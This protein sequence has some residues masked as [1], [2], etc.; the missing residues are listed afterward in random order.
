LVPDPATVGNAPVA[1]PPLR[2]DK[3]C[4]CNRCHK[5]INPEFD[6]FRKRI[7]D[8]FEGK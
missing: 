8:Y 1:E 2:E 4:S 6:P 3:A 7:V 5:S